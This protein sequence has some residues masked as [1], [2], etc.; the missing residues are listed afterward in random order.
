VRLGEAHTIQHVITSSE[1]RKISARQQQGR[2]GQPN[3]ERTNERTK[4]C[5]NWRRGGDREGSGERWTSRRPAG[6]AIC[7]LE[8]HESETE[9]EQF[10]H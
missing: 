9:V 4:E 1:Q 3:N 2:A 7:S 5:S 8:V 6:H 10:C